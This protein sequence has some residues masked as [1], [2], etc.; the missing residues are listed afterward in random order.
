[1]ELYELI[2]EMKLLERLL[3]VTAMEPPIVGLIEPL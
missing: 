1:M 3:I 2:L